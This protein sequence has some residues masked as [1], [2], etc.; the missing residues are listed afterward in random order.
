M[1]LCDNQKDIT[2]NKGTPEKV[3]HTSP[4]RYC[5]S[6][7]SPCMW[8]SHRPCLLYYYQCVLFQHGL[9]RLYADGGNLAIGLGLDVI[10]HLH[11]FQ[12]H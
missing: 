4:C 7:G 6:L 9:A 2:N 12:H 11:G 10:G 3:F 1:Q 8:G 5:V